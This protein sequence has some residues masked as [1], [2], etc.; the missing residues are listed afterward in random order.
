M[1][2]LAVIAAATYSLAVYG[3]QNVLGWGVDPDRYRA[4]CP[5]YRHYSMA[6]QYVPL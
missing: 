4:A 6:P 2:L 3:E 5:D 1:L